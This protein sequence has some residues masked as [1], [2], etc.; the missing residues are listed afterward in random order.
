MTKIWR[1]GTYTHKVIIIICL[2]DKTCDGK[3]IEHISLFVSI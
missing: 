1:E 2:N 3:E